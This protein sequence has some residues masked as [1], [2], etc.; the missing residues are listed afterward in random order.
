MLQSSWTAV[1]IGIWY[2]SNFRFGF[3]LK[4]HSN[5]YQ[6]PE[7]CAFLLWVLF[8]I[9]WAMAA[10]A[11][12]VFNRMSTTSGV[13]ASQRKEGEAA[14][15]HD[16][17]EEA[18]AVAGDRALTMVMHTLG[19]SFTCLAFISGSVPVVQVSGVNL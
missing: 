14:K 15:A 8:A 11:R 3:G 12:L 10:A 2:F 17:H 18:A 6:D 5:L 19:M 9:G 7:R 13:A 16:E 1:L 4:R